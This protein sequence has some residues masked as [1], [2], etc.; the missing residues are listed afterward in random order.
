MTNKGTGRG[1]GK[2]KYRGLSASVEMT[3]IV[4]RA[5]QVSPLRMTMRLSCSGRDEK[6]VLGVRR[7]TFGLKPDALS[8]S[9]R[10]EPK[11]PGY[12]RFVG[13]DVVQGRG[14]SHAVMGCVDIL[15]A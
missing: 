3:E 11:G 6:I 13:S 7:H 1:K 8:P 10:P 12:L 4:V 9:M 5:M 2:G 14:I 15:S